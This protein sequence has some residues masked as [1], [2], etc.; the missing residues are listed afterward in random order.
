MSSV[1]PCQRAYLDAIRRFAEPSGG[2]AEVELDWTC[3]RNIPTHLESATAVRVF[4]ALVRKGLAREQDGGGPI[5]CRARGDKTARGASQEVCAGCGHRGLHRSTRGPRMTPAQKR[6][7]IGAASPRKYTY[8]LAWGG[9]MMRVDPRVV[10]SLR[11]LGLVDASSWDVRE[12]KG[13][14][15]AEG[16]RVAEALIAKQK[17]PK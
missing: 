8:G 9:G 15:T 10:R 17:A 6:A 12:G 1:T 14:L 4:Q 13:Y 16:R 2:F 11:A 3:T 5:L 7:L